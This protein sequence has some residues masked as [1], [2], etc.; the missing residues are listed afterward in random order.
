MNG[1]AQAI[2]RLI[3]P[4]RRDFTRDYLSRGRPVILE[5]VAQDWPALSRWTPEYFRTRFGSRKVSIEIWADEAPGAS[6]ESHF[7]H[8]VKQ[9]P[10][11]EYLD[12]IAAND[13][14]KRYYLAQSAVT[15]VAPELLEDLRDL[16][17]YPA[18]IRK[19]VQPVLMFFGPEGTVTPF[20]YDP[21]HNILVQ[22]R[23]RK[24][25]VMVSP[26]QSGLLYHPYKLR[27]M[28]R[29]NYSPVDPLALDEARFPLYLKTRRL[30]FVLEEGEALFIP[31]GWWHHVVSLAPS[32]NVTFWWVTLPMLLG[33]AP[34]VWAT[35]LTNAVRRLLGRPLQDPYA[36][37]L[38]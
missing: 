8:E 13:T 7:S 17:Y 12:L 34:R 24:R 18:W 10:L 35:S 19:L 3:R 1:T 4:T 22:V 21:T 38:K 11:A 14:G 2:D 27:E 20:H 32:V 33:M 15:D 36:S 25:V 28:E 26:D 37:L 23:G 16:P 9:M 5:G 6:A 30:E 31:A 29:Y